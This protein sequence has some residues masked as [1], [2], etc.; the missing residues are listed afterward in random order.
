MSHDERYGYLNNVIY[1]IAEYW[2]RLYYS[3]W[4]KYEQI[5]YYDL[6]EAKVDFVFSQQL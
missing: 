6:P 4:R 3:D 5:S 2:G 1:F